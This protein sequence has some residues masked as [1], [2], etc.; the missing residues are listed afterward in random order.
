V[1]LC[2]K[3]EASPV[4]DR[5]LRQQVGELLDE[6]L[7]PPRGDDLPDGLVA[8]SRHTDSLGLGAHD[9]A[10]LSRR[11]RLLGPLF[12]ECDERGDEAWRCGRHTEILPGDQWRVRADFVPDPRPCDRVSQAAGRQGQLVFGPEPVAQSNA[13][14]SR[15]SC[16]SFVPSRTITVTY[17][18][19][20]V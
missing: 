5:E 8:R 15:A 16:V 18:Y 12:G 13:S 10:D 17:L 9:P 1:T 14:S 2:H 20:R 4:A 19:C 11:Q 6:E 3:L 7:A